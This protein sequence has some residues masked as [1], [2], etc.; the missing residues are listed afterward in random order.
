MN[1]KWN[2]RCFF[3]MHE[4]IDDIVTDAGHTYRHRYCRNCKRE[5]IL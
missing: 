5:D 2:W 1:W 3:G 4:W